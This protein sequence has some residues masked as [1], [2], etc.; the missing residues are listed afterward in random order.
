MGASIST[1]Q[2]NSHSNGG[3]IPLYPARSSSNYQLIPTCD[4]EVM[5]PSRPAVPGDYTPTPY[6][7]PDHSRRRPPRYSPGWAPPWC[8][9]NGWNGCGPSNGGR[10]WW[11]W[12]PVNPGSGNV[13]RC[14]FCGCN[15]HDGR[16]CSCGCGG[17]MAWPPNG[18]GG[19]WDGGNSGGGGGGCGPTCTANDGGVR[20]K[21][22]WG[23]DELDFRVGGRER[24]PCQGAGGC[25]ATYRKAKSRSRSRSRSRRRRRRERKERDGDSGDERG[26]KG[27]REQNGVRRGRSPSVRLEA[28]KDGLMFGGSGMGMGMRGGVDLNGENEMFQRRAPGAMGGLGGMRQRRPRRP[29][30]PLFDRNDGGFGPPDDMDDFEDNFDMGPEDDFDDQS[31]GP[32]GRARRGGRRGGM[33][34]R[35]PPRRGRPEMPGAGFGR[36]GMGGMGDMDGMDDFNPMSRGG[37]GS[38]KGGPPGARRRKPPRAGGMRMGAPPPDFPESLPNMISGARAP[39]G[40]GPPDA[41]GW[42]DEDLHMGHEQPHQFP[43]RGHS[44]PHHFGP[45]QPVGGGEPE[46]PPPDPLIGTFPHTPSGPPHDPRAPKLPYPPPPEMT[47]H[48]PPPPPPGQDLPPPPPMPPPPGVRPS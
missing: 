44:M 39:G 23:K 30:G 22:K 25:D 29:P 21:G 5:A 18:G 48:P 12:W 36:G 6:P 20:V 7:P 11:D 8:P 47:G 2:T 3:T 17:M 46:W 16:V 38:R 14:S 41:D 1:A 9:P 10:G 32:G 15:V 27:D 34:G 37:G 42:E 35:P 45:P 26:R 24:C 28:F 4:H 31:M 43:P 19:G 13:M 40:M 33:G